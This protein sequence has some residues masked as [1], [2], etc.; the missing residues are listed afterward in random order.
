MQKLKKVVD[1]Y[2]FSNLHVAFATFCLTQITLLYAGVTNHIFSYFVF[3]ATF[4]A[5][6]GIRFYRKKV[7]K[8]WLFDWMQ[9]N[10]IPLYIF[11]IIS[12]LALLFLGYNLHVNTLL[13]LMPAGFLTL[14]YV[15]PFR[16]KLSLRTLSGFKIFLIAFCWAFVTVLL[17]LVATEI[18][19]T[20]DVLIT[21]FQRFFFVLAI[22]I[23]FDIRDVNF[24]IKSL[25]TLPQF[26]GIK[27][28]KRI[29]TFFLMLFLGLNFLKTEMDTTQL[30]IELIITIISLLLLMRATSN[31]HKYYSA[32]FVEAIP[33]VWYLLLLL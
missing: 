23:P 12:I 31:Q 20:K 4:L 28:S 26:F 29:G 3:F 1:F 25:K 21:F 33:I 30:R 10:K 5:Y 2:V 7:I 22:T 19:F 16:G 8:S 24:D 17:P 11:L 27:Q 9:S 13:A 18:A 15:V 14:F 6:N 32:L